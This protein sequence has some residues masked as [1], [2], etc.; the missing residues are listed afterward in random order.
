MVVV[1]HE[2]RSTQPQ[3]DK[4]IRHTIIQKEII[5][6]WYQF[7]FCKVTG[8]TEDDNNSWICFLTVVH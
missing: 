2:R 5:K 8:A 4:F 7:S 6:G 1:I 3:Y